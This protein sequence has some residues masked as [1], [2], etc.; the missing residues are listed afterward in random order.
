[1]IEGFDQRIIDSITAEGF[2]TPGLLLK[3]TIARLPPTLGGVYSAAM[4]ARDETP[5]RCK[6]QS[7]DGTLSVALVFCFGICLY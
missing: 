7:S 1:M 6:K 4:I 2:A 5:V 3:R